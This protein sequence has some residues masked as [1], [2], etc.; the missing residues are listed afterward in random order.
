LTDKTAIVAGGGLPGHR[1]PL[2]ILSSD[3]RRL[4]AVAPEASQGVD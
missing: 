4:H 1:G 2:G 3:V